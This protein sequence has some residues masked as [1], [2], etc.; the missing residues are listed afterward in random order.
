MGQFNSRGKA[1]KHRQVNSTWYDSLLM[2]VAGSWKVESCCHLIL[3][4]T[5]PSVSSS[6]VDIHIIIFC[7]Q[8]IY[9]SVNEDMLTLQVRNV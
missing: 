3:H 4:R 7:V 8:D 2:G 9:S 5:I 1:K 6:L